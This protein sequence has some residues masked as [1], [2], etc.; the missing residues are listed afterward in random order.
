MSQAPLPLVGI[1]RWARHLPPGRMTCE[2][3]GAGY[4][5]SGA[6]V[7]EDTGMAEKAIG[8]PGQSALDFGLEAAKKLMQGVDPSGIDL[9][10]FASASLP[11]H[12][13]WWA[14]YRI[15][16]ELGLKDA[17]LHEMRMGCLGSLHALE[18]AKSMIQATPGLNRVLLVTGE[19]WHFDAAF[20][21][22]CYSTPGNEPWMIFGDGGAAVLLESSE[23]A[24]LSNHLG[25]FSF[26]VDAEHHGVVPIRTGGSKNYV[27]PEQVAQ[28]LHFLHTQPQTPEELKRFGLRYL[29]QMRATVREALERAGG[30]TKPDFL[31]PSQLKK[32]LMRLLSAKLGIPLERVTQTMLTCGHVGTCDILMGMGMALD[33]HFMQP[34]ETATIVSSGVS[35]GWGAATWHGL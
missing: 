30:T 32:P 4:G 9:V 28:G 1:T 3:A 26:R 34:G 33:G 35:F 20:K 31:V 22:A 16:H 17:R 13:C 29:T 2:E 25:A 15:H 24:T 14:P 18:V 5:L 23:V 7:L 21:E 8:E 27:G 11:D 6:Q 12:P 19:A 10:I